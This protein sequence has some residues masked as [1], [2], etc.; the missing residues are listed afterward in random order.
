LL[1]LGSNQVQV[2]GL[3]V[4]ERVVDRYQGAADGVL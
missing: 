4:V 1:G 2:D 3:G